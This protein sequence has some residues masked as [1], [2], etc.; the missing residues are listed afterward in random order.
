MY[1]ELT[2]NRKS[3]GIKSPQGNKLWLVEGRM[4]YD[5]FVLNEKRAA[6][7]YQG[8]QQVLGMLDVRTFAAGSGKTSIMLNGT[9]ETGH[10]LG[11]CTATDAA[12][13]KAVA[14]GTA[15]TSG[16]FTAMDTNPITITPTTGHTVVRVVELDSNGKAVAYGDALINL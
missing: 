10:T 5:C 1:A 12:N 7:F 11:Y 15:P 9:A 8:S 2:G 4:I 16:D 6:V 13:L 3:C 14:Y